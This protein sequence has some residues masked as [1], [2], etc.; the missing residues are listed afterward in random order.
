MGIG[1]N[2]SSGL[3]SMMASMSSQALSEEPSNPKRMC[4]EDRL[5]M[6]LARGDTP[7]ESSKGPSDQD[8]HHDHAGPIPSRDLIDDVEED[9]PE[10]SDLE[11]NPS[12]FS[13]DSLNSFE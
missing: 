6:A 8:Q 12:S 9:M 3:P 1:R 11:E 7:D 13:E 4:F 2:K 10:P 5:K